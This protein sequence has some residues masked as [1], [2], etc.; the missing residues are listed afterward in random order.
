MKRIR[1]CLALLLAMLLL[2]AALPVS[3]LAATKVKTLKYNTWYST[4]D[5][6]ASSRIAYRLKLTAA[7]V[8]YV[9]W[10][11]ANANS[12]FAEVDFC[13]DTD[14]SYVVDGME[15][16][17]PASGR[18]GFLLYPGTYY[19]GI[20]DIVK[21]AKVKF[22][23]VKASRLKKSNTTSGKAISLG[24]GKKAEAI[25]TRSGKAARWYKLKL[26]KKQA[27]RLYVNSHF[28]NQG[29]DVTLYSSKL[30]KIPLE[31]DWD[32]DRY[33]SKQKLAKGTYYIKLSADTSFLDERGYYARVYWK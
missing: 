1:R 7:T 29:G 26:T 21:G 23:A 32:N 8:V 20:F 9:N 5:P 11:N 3:G 27:V 4:Q 17:Y 13:K 12:D 16:F 28:F 19:V 14:C 24:S 31:E 30:K 25:F 33:L 22:S 2:L 10:K 18:E 15:M 6:A